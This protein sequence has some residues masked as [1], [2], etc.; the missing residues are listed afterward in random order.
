MNW[1]GIFLGLFSL[2]IIG[3]GF[4]WVFKLEYYLGYLWWPYPL[5]LGIFIV[6]SSFF[7]AQPILSAMLGIVGASF[8]WGATE[9][10]TLALKVEQGWFKQNPKPKPL[11]PGVKWI[12]RLKAPRM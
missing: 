10:E 12:R 1:S 5:V 6:G 8:I 7:V 4:V 9:L 3:F 2:G 11:P